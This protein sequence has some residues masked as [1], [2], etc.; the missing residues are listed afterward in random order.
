MQQIVEGMMAMVFLMLF[1]V[2]G[3]DLIS[4]EVNCCNAREFRNSVIMALENSEF[5]ESVIRDCFDKAKK[6][7][8]DLTMTFHYLDGE[9]TTITNGSVY[10]KTKTILIAEVKLAYKLRVPI[11]GSEVY[12][13][14]QAVTC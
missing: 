5:D 7:G 14:T 6:N 3:I 12:K 10:A 9:T 11:L 13:K 1:L 4:V 2:T 8:Y